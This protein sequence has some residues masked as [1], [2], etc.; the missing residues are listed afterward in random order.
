M[1]CSDENRSCGCVADVLERILQLQ[2]DD[3]ENENFAGCD[4]PYL[5]PTCT[6]VCYNTRPI[7]LFNCC[8]CR[9]GCAI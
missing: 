3:Y 7:M 9:N 1:N 5:G 8:F 6:T 2:N 4:K